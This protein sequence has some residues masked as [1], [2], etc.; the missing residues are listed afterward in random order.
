MRLDQL[1]ILGKP[2]DSEDQIELILEGLPEDYKSVIDQIEGKDATPSITE[3]HER[4]LNQEAKLL[5]AI[6]A[7]NLAYPVTANAVQH[8]HSNN[9]SRTSHLK[10]KPTNNFNNNQWQSSTGNQQQGTRV[11]KPY[12]GKC[13]LCHVQGHSA[14]RCP[15]FQSLQPMV[16]Q[17]QNNSFRPWQPRANMVVASPYTANNWVVDSGATHHITS[18]LNNLSLHQA[19][20][21]EDDVMIA[22]GSSLQITHTGST[23][24]PSQTRALKLNRVLCVPNINKNLVSVYRLCNANKVSMEFFPASFQV[25]DLS[26]GVPLLQGQTNGELYE[27]PVDP[28]QAVALTATTTSKNTMSFWH[29]RLGHP[30]FSILNNV[31]SKLSPPIF[32]TSKH[33]IFCS[34][35]MINKSHKLPFA[36]SSIVST[37]PLE[38]IF[39]DLWTSPILSI[40]NYK[41]YIILVDHYTRYTCLYPLKQKSQVKQTF[42]AFKALVENRFQSTI[43]TLY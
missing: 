13:Q 18:D 43:G 22:D 36:T 3:V 7:P 30:S 29:S 1:A 19:Y 41:Y 6:P 15:Q 38:I 8:R 24:L 40:D 39:T 37:R 35:C 5:A 34:D 26:T 25:K 4:L 27:W 12:L 10:Q 9:Q 17:F 11:S 20:N 16:N 2:L 14:K 23:L 31:V 32:N 42:M 21:G 28:S 33:L